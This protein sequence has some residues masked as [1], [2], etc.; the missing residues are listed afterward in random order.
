MFIV[1]LWKRKKKNK[2]KPG[3]QPSAVSRQKASAESTYLKTTLKNVGKTWKKIS[4]ERIH[5]TQTI[6][7]E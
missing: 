5:K 2:R 4:A 1:F 7:M 3:C 6:K